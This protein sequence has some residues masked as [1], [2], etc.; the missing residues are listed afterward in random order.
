[1]NTNYNLSCD[2]VMDLVAVYKDGL[3]SDDTRE[4]VR[5]H[6]RTCPS[7]RRLYAEYRVS[8]DVRAGAPTPP[9][10]SADNYSALARLVHRQ[11]MISSAA[12]L[13]VMAISAAAGLYCVMKGLSSSEEDNGRSCHFYK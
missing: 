12:M 8:Q 5:A 3:A 4:L 7:C 10:L 13:S 11:H 1:M 2:V 9:P 6:L